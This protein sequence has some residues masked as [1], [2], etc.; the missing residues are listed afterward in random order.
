MTDSAGAARRPRFRTTPARLVGDTHV[1]N[2]LSSADWKKVVK[3]QKDLKAPGIILQLDAYAKA[4]G[5]KD[6]LEQVAV[7]NELLDEIKNAKSKNSKNKDLLT[8]L[9]SMTKESN[10]TIGLLE[11]QAVKRAKD[12]AKAKKLQEE[13]EDEGEE[14]ESKAL[15]Q[16]LLQMV[17]RLKMAKID[18][19]LRFAVVMKSPKEGALALSK[20]KVTPDQIKEAKSNADGGRVVARGICFT[21]EGKSIFETPKEVPAALSKVVKFFVFRDTGKKIKPIFRVREDLVDEAEEGEGPETGGASAVKLAKLKIAWN[22]AKQNAGQQ[23]VALKKAII[24]EHDDA[25]AA[26]AAARLD[27]VIVQ[28]NEGLSETLDSFYTAEL[29]QRPALREKLITILNNYLVFVKN[30][31]LVAHI[32]DNP[33][34]PVTIRATLAAPLTEL[35][36]ELAG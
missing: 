30:S 28:F 31:P 36:L 4:E 24:A 12:D 23:L 33:F 35:Q 8:Y 1:P 7:L 17:K 34:Q 16:E 2:Y 26:E 27:E 22:Q 6:P 3:D 13:E 5:K 29:E 18:Q 25:E 20:K 11:A 15:N 32:E 10:K 9:D 14:D 21:E 19:P